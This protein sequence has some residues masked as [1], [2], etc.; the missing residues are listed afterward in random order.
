[1]AQMWLRCGSELS[2]GGTKHFIHFTCVRGCTAPSCIRRSPPGRSIPNAVRTRR[3]SQLSRERRLRHGAPPAPPRRPK[4][5]RVEGGYGERM[6]FATKL[7]SIECETG[8]DRG[9]GWGRRRGR[10]RARGRDRDE[11]TC[12]KAAMENGPRRSSTQPHDSADA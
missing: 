6:P 12:V 7:L 5:T 3:I 1:V 9:W 2:P 8:M 10:A 4:P 11:P